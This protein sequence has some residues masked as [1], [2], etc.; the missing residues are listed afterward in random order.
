[1]Y[2]RANVVNFVPR[3]LNLLSKRTAN[4]DRAEKQD[5]TVD[6]GGRVEIRFGAGGQRVGASQD[7][8]TKGKSHSYTSA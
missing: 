1:M 8:S 6:G 7:R 2:A 5:T 3:G 4:E